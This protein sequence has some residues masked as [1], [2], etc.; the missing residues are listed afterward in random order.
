M[1][2]P[3][4]KEHWDGYRSLVVILAENPAVYIRTKKKWMSALRSAFRT[5]MR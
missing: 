4:L 2:D 5:P 1:F 3:K